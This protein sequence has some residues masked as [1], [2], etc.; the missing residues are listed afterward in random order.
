MSFLSL[1]LSLSLFLSV[2]LSLLTHLLLQHGLPVWAHAQI[3]PEPCHGPNI[4][5][6]RAQARVPHWSAHATLT[7]NQVTTHTPPQ[8]HSYIKTTHIN[9]LKSNQRICTESNKILYRVLREHSTMG[10]GTIE[11]EGAQSGGQLKVRKEGVGSIT[12]NVNKN[13]H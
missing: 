10:E 5:A 13:K 4:D 7:N 11:L 9:T 6:H 3:A 1:S 2:S 12:K 8:P